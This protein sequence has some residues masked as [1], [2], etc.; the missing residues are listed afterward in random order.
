MNSARG[1]QHQKHVFQKLSRS[2]QFAENIFT[3]SD[4]EL[5][6]LPLWV[7]CIYLGPPDS[8][9]RCRVCVTDRKCC[10]L[11]LFSFDGEYRKTVL[12][13]IRFHPADSFHKY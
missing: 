9:V 2:E 4:T 3:C 8:L 10:V 5:F 1:I 11:M 12:E 13:V 6:H 7:S